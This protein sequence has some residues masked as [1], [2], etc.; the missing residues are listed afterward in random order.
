[1]CGGV[2]EAEL[3]ARPGQPQLYKACSRSEAL[4]WLGPVRPLLVPYRARSKPPGKCGQ[5]SGRIVAVQKRA[6][7]ICRIA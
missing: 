4:R 7:L 5:E 1:M 6:G 3:V 2:S